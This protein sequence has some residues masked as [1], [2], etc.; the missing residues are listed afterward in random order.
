MSENIFRNLNV[1][2]AFYSSWYKHHVYTK[3]R[4]SVENEKLILLKNPLSTREAYARLVAADKAV[5]KEIGRN[6]YYYQV[7]YLAGPMDRLPSVRL[8]KIATQ[9]LKERLN[10]VVTREGSYAV[11]SEA[12]PLMTRL[13]EA[14]YCAALQ[15]ESLPLIVIFPD[16]GDLSRHRNHQ[17]KRYEP[18]LTHLNMKGFR[19]LDVLDAF[20]AYD[21]NVPKDQL[22]VGMWGHYSPLGNKIVASSLHSYLQKDS[23]VSKARIKSLAREALANEKCRPN[24]PD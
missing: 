4:F 20:V 1:F 6:D 13:F 12:F 16:L 22:T 8:F 3:P 24:A 10:P 15:H 2:R 23:L 11:A 18:L 5:L 7:G 21:S 19:Y 14:F 17:P 9:I